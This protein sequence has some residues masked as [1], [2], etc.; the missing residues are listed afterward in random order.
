MCCVCVCVQ[1]VACAPCGGHTVCGVCTR[2][3]QLELGF[4][5]RLIFSVLLY[6]AT[7]QIF[8]KFS[9][10]MSFLSLKYLRTTH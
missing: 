2:V 8:L 5:P 9:R 3:Q 1:C 10:I 7:R 6:L 4:R